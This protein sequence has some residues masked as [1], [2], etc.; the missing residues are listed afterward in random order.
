M[1]D[2]C[3]YNIPDRTLLFYAHYIF[4]RESFDCFAQRQLTYLLCG[5]HVIQSRYKDTNSYRR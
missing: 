2:T 1:M 5:T 3:Y 4:L